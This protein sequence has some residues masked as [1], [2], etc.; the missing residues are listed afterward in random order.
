M[1]F[2]LKILSG[3]AKVVDPDQT[4]PSEAA[5]SGSALFAYAILS[6]HL[7]FENLAYMTVHCKNVSDIRRLKGGPQ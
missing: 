4:A 3:M 2:F 7:M 5:L 1:Y 6:D